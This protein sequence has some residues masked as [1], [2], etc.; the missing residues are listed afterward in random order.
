M[1]VVGSPVGWKT[2]LVFRMNEIVHYIVDQREGVA[3]PEVGEVCNKG[4]EVHMSEEEGAG[5]L[6]F[7]VQEDDPHP[8][9][10]S[11]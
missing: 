4:H 2:L 5:S 10:C 7:Q 11:G 9:N 3:Y 1:G 8:L 6:G